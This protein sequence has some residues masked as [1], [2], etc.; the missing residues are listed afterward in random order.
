VSA[1]PLLLFVRSD[2][3]DEWLLKDTGGSVVG[4]KEQRNSSAKKRDQQR[5]LYRGTVE[6]SALFP[7]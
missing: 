5:L 1:Y 3:G 7:G 2:E 6:K 4:Y